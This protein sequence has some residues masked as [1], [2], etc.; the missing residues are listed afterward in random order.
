MKKKIQL[1][2]ILFLF[3]WIASA[4]V[5]FSL[6]TQSRVT[7]SKSLGYFEE[8]KMRL[9]GLQQW[10]FIE[11]ELNQWLVRV[12][13][14]VARHDMGE[15]FL[16]FCA[17]PPTP[18]YAALENRLGFDFSVGYD[19]LKTPKHDVIASIGFQQSWTT[20]KY[21][22][23]PNDMFLFPVFSEEPLFYAGST[24]GVEYRFI[25]GDH[26]QIGAQWGGAYLYGEGEY[27]R[28]SPWKMTSAASV[29][30]RF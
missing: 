20:K 27:P 2:A 30:Y 17:T 25:A 18:T 28:V 14:S 19:F 13:P 11:A 10:V 3:T 1:T 9:E 26:W 23:V 15:T 4:Q 5:Q 24:L 29:G 21:L 16:G 7:F 8:Q 6:A 12:G 22:D